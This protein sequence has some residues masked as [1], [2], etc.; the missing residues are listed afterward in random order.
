MAW[1]A[2]YR[3]RLSKPLES[4]AKELQLVM[5]G[6]AAVLSGDGKKPLRES[7]WL[8]INVD[9]LESREEADRF[10][11][12]LGRAVILAGARLDIGIDVGEDRATASFGQ[13]VFDMFAERGHV[14]QPNVHGLYIYEHKGN[15]AFVHVDATGTVTANATS[16]FDAMTLAFDEV[17]G[18]GEREH[19]ALV[20]LALSKVAHEPLAEAALCISAVN[21]FRQ[22]EIGRMHNAPC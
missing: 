22:A 21:S 18:I 4:D 2:R 15:E 20:L 14:L 17:A 3:F 8:T 13:A 12:T 19:T 11:R 7:H 9:D 1:T 6:R 5:G 10:G 16:L